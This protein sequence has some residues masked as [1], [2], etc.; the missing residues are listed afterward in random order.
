MAMSAPW[1]RVFHSGHPNEATARSCHMSRKSPE[2][3]PKANTPP[4]QWNQSPGTSRPKRALQLLAEVA[5]GVL[6]VV[7]QAR[8]GHGPRAE[9][10]D[11]VLP[12]RDVGGEGDRVPGAGRRPP[13]PP[14]RTAMMSLSR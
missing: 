13:P 3:G 9:A 14:A 6:V 11:R 2:S 8:A 10:V 5:A 4:F 1:S 12:D 7:A